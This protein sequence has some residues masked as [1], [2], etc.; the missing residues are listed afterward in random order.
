VSSPEPI[1]DLARGDVAVSRQ[2]SKALRV[3]LAGTADPQLKNQIRAILDGQ[4]SARE[5]MR[6]DAFN[7]VLDQTMPAAM[8]QFADMPEDERQRLAA[9]GRAELDRLRDQPPGLFSPFRP[10]EPP[11]TPAPPVAP[12]LPPPPVTAAPSVRRKSYKDQV[13]TPDE[14]DEDDLYFSERRKNGWLQ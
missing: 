12:Q 11:P 14:P 13:V 1:H 3:I 8:Q 9:Q 10:V 6:S 5:L 2:L 7:V 4:G